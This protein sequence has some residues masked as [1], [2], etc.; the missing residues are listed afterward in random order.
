MLQFWAPQNFSLTIKTAL[1]DENLKFLF[2]PNWLLLTFVASQLPPPPLVPVVLI[3]KPYLPFEKY[4][5]PSSH[6]AVDQICLWIW[7]LRRLL[8]H[9]CSLSL[10]LSL[11]LS[12]TRSL[13]WRNLI[14]NLLA[15]LYTNHLL[16]YSHTTLSPSLTH[17]HF[18]TLSLFPHPVARSVFLSRSQLRETQTPC[19]VTRRLGY[20]LSI[21]RQ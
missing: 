1:Y 10:S 11:S 2:L 6:L 15:F 8:Q 3:Q 17:T 14:H 21:C 4:W 13:Y 18:N 5:L 9:L 20:S 12:G 7:L 19:S 16:L